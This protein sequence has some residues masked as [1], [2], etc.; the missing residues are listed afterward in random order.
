M[1]HI[2]SSIRD[3]IAIIGALLLHSSNKR[4]DEISGSQHD[5]YTDT[6]GNTAIVTEKVSHTSGVVRYSGANWRARLSEESTANCIDAGS[7]VTIE[8]VDGNVLIVQRLV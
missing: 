5:T 3:A 7:R 4:F 2:F 6:I 8:S 1:K